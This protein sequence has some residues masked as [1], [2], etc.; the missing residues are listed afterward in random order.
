[1]A[2][3]PGTEVV[4]CVARF[5]ARFYRESVDLGQEAFCSRLRAG[6][7]ATSQPPAGV[8]APVYQ[9]AVDRGRRV[10][11]IHS[12]FR[13]SGILDVARSAARELPEGG[14]DVIDSR[15]ASLGAGLMTVAAAEAAR[16][17]E[18]Q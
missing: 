6:R 8:F 13:L 9:Q 4:P 18:S 12:S 14:V 3:R 11:S 5:G 1:M 15:S 17:G 2:R 7:A 16:R 10:L